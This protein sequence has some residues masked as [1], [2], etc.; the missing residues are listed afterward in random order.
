VLLEGNLGKAKLQKLLRF[1]LA[2]IYKNGVASLEEV[3]PKEQVQPEEVEVRLKKE[4]LP[5]E[6]A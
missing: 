4:T 3:H 1:K 5:E 6:E 2:G